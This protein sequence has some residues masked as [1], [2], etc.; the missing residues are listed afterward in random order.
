MERERRVERSAEIV[1]CDVVNSNARAE[2]L[3]A[4]IEQVVRAMPEAGAE[5]STVQ[6]ERTSAVPIC[7]FVKPE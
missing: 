4:L 3:V 2:N 1:S 5:N 7:A 6:D